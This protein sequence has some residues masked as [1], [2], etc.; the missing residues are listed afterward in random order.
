[1]LSCF[2]SNSAFSAPAAPAPECVIIG[3]VEDVSSRDHVYSPRSWADSWNLPKSI[4]YTDINIKIL[5][6]SF[7]NEEDVLQFPDYNCGDIGIIKKYQLPNNQKRPPINSC[8][9]AIT[10]YSGDEFKIG[11]WLK[12]L[13]I[14][15]SRECVNR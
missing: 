2:F 5:E 15:D 1:M 8:I 6:S 12:R 11:N 13:K 14:L 10:Q 4:T 7:L 9:K 3:I